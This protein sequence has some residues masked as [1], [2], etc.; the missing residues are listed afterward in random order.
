MNEKETLALLIYCNELDGRH[1]PNEIK[2][3]AWHDVFKDSV[4]LMTAS[5]AH[6]VARKHYGML[7]VMISPSTFVKAWRDSQ[8]LRAANSVSLDENA[9]DRHCRRIDCQCTHTGVCYRGWIDTYEKTVPCRICRSSLM[10]VLE[11]IPPLGQRQDHDEA[12]IRNRFKE[13]INY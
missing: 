2:V 7:D 1:A 13:Q 3:Q 10:Q 9:A 11:E 12:R 6:D 4:P 5:F 8:K